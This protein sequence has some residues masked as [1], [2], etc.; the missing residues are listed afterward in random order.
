MVGGVAPP[1]RWLPGTVSALA[2]PLL[3]A[4]C[5][6][7]LDSLGYEDRV[8]N[9]QDILGG[10][11]IE[12]DRIED[13]QPAFDPTRTV[14]EIFRRPWCQVTMNKSATVTKLDIVPFDG[15]RGHAQGQGVSGTRRR[16]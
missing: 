5:L 9:K 12:D 14:V 6:G 2:L 11:Q 1:T 15:E 3:V 8:T 7:P 16:R 10:M 13:K 4:G